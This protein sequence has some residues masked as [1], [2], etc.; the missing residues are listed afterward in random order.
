MR[1]YEQVSTCW[2]TTDPGASAVRSERI[3]LQLQSS[4]RDEERD[5][6]LSWMFD[7]SHHSETW[8]FVHGI[9]PVEPGGWS[10]DRIPEHDS[11]QDQAKSCESWRMLSG[12]G[13]LKQV[14][15]P[16]AC[17]QGLFFGGTLS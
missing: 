15:H 13:M 1:C 5:T 7:A 12:S 17:I 6:A 11:Q 4:S 14:S 2:E 9:L 3:D 10:D 8:H 16:G